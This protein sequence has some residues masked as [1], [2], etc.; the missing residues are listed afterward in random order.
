MTGNVRVMHII[1]P[2]PQIKLSTREWRKLVKLV[3]EKKNQQGGE[4]NMVSI[5][6]IHFVEDPCQS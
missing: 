2:S 3:R 5:S 6:G 4:I 1:L